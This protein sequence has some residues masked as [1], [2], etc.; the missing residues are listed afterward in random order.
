MS[1]DSGDERPTSHGGVDPADVCKEGHFCKFGSKILVFESLVA[2]APRTLGRVKDGVEIEISE[3]ELRLRGLAGICWVG[4]GEDPVWV[5]EYAVKK[6]ILEV[7]S[8]E[9]MTVR[10]LEGDDLFLLLLLVRSGGCSGHRWAGGGDA[11][12]VVVN[13][14]TCPNREESDRQPQQIIIIIPVTTRSNKRQLFLKSNPPSLS[15]PR[16][17]LLSPM[18]LVRAALFFYLLFPLNFARSQRVSIIDQSDPNS[19]RFSGS[20]NTTWYSSTV[21]GSYAFTSG[22]ADRVSIIFHVRPAVHRATP[23]LNPTPPG[24]LSPHVIS[25][26]SFKHP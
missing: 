11:V 1:G 7:V 20:W 19:V 2:W 13:C 18:A 5:C 12:V 22:P 16:A 23:V 26:S 4:V 9:R 15:L 25:D 3:G 10:V 6:I 14:Q 24:G 8:G 17:G 21:G